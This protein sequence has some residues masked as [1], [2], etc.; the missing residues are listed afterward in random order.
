MKPKGVDPVSKPIGILAIAVLHAVKRNIALYGYA[1]RHV[2]M[3]EDELRS[4]EN[5]NCD[6]GIVNITVI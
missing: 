4:G 3:L 2:I 6:G 1:W 5:W